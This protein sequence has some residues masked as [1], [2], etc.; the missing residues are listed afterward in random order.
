M[1][2][3]A[4]EPAGPIPAFRLFPELI[5]PSLP[6]PADGDQPLSSSLEGLVVAFSIEE[7][8]FNSDEGERGIK[9]RRKEKGMIFMDEKLF[10]TKIQTFWEQRENDWS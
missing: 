1:R 4:N 8:T 6:H 9:E 2:G 7:R 3:K 5:P 10:R